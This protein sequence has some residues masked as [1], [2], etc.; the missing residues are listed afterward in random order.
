MRA[1]RSY[2][3]RLMVNSQF[4]QERKIDM[5]PKLLK[6][7]VWSLVSLLVMIF[8]AC[9]SDSS[10]RGT[11]QVALTDD[12][13]PSLKEVVISIK[14]VRAVP[15]GSENSTDEGLPLIKTFEPS[16]SVNVLDLAYQ[17]EVLGEALVP[18]GAYNQVR[19]ILDT[20]MENEDPVNYVTLQD[21]SIAALDPDGL[22]LTTPSAQTSGLKILG[23]FTVR[24]GEMTAI[25]LDF[26][27]SKAVHESSQDKWLLKP[28]GIRI[29]EIEDV[30]QNYGAISGSVLPD[31]ESQIIASAVVSVV[32]VGSDAPIATGLVNPEDGSFRALLPEGSYFLT[33]DADGFERYTS[34][35]AEP[36]D[37]VVGE[38]TDVEPVA[39]VG[40][41][42]EPP[43]LP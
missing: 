14:E 30:L 40:V 3:A 19:L 4:L 7:F 22:A 6:I 38:E 24:P 32:P 2:S 33:V 31:L 43:T 29:V 5:N 8:A 42:A 1:K 34:D 20:N 25:V 28:T 27:P 13:D 16:L 10:S 26:D 36:F 11:L 35:P 41:A 21:D 39:L 17:Q 15:N 23:K 9:G 18:A 37:V 12:V